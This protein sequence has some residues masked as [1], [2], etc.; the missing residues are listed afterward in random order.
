MKTDRNA[1]F[2]GMYFLSERIFSLQAKRAEKYFLTLSV[3]TDFDL[4]Y[5]KIG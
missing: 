5:L 2:I 3:C 4:N 1:F